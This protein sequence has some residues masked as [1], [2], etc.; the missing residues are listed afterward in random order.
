MRSV[1][2]QSH[3]GLGAVVSQELLVKFDKNSDKLHFFLPGYLQRLITATAV[4]E[5]L[6][7]SLIL[8]AVF[9]EVL[10]R[11]TGQKSV[12]IRFHEDAAASS[13]HA[14][15][16]NLSLRE[17]V[18]QLQ[19]VGLP[20]VTLDGEFSFQRDCEPPALAQQETSPIQCWMQ[21]SA[22]E[23]SGTLQFDRKIWDPAVMPYFISSY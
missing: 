13:I 19:L 15:E 2:V 12:G 9:Q 18:E 23:L 20:S 17:T 16:E 11:Y 7:E 4:A 14:L 6:P 8:L 22:E 10:R 1:V 3:V 21:A 5:R